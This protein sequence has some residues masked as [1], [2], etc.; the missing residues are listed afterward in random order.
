VTASEDDPTTEPKPPPVEETAPVAA[1]PTPAP[2]HP[3]TTAPGVLKVA[4][5]ASIAAGAIHATAAGAHSEP[6]SAM[7]AFVITAVAQLAWGAWALSRSGTLVSLV[8]VAVNGAAVGGWLLAKTSGISFIDGLD[9]KESPQ[10]ADTLCAVLALVAV[11]GAI[12]ALM[13]GFSFFTRANPALVGVAA[14]AALGL[15]VPGMVRTG[16]H[17]HAG[18]HD[19]SETAGGHSHGT[20]ETAAATPA[21]PYDA[22]LPVDLGGVPGVTPEQQAEAE[23]L[24]TISLEKLP[25]F[26]D[27]PTIEAMGYHSIGDAGTGNEHFIKWDLISDGRVLDPDYPESLVFDVDRATGQKTLAAAMFMANPDDTLDTVTP[28]GGDLV[29]WHIHDNLCYA[30]QAGAWRVA[31]VAPPDQPCPNGTTRLSDN[32]V[33][34]VHVWI[35]PHA[36]GPFAALEGV[37]AGQIASGEERLCDHAHGA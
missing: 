36:C 32:P 30:G 8:G 35:R 3:A 12:A 23:Q 16:G 15:A 21:K 11:A 26:A 5:F 34:M 31:G 14:I 20:G 33:P 25:Q 2:A 17:S 9:T 28:I 7:V 29:Q 24:V 22:T 6:R 1:D 19:H 18:G 4:A 10:F 13:K 27:I 37:G